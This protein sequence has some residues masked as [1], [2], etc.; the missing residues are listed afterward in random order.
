MPTPVLP[1]LLAAAAPPASG[2]P[3]DGAAHG[4]KALPP[5]L[6]ALDVGAP[7]SDKVSWTTYSHELGALAVNL[8]VAIVVLIATTWMARTLS[9]V[10]RRLLTR[11]NHGEVDG[12]LP[13]FGASVTRYLVTIIGVVAALQQ[14]GVRTTSVLAVLGA[15]SLAVGLALQGALSNVAA[16]VMIMLFRPYRIGHYVEIGGKQGVVKNLDL[17]ATEMATPDNLRV[18]VPNSKVFGDVITNWSAHDRRRVDVVFHVP[19]Q[20]DLH[21]VLEGLKTYLAGHPLAID[22]PEPILEAMTLN[23]LYAE[24]AVRVWVKPADYTA[25]RTALVLEAQ[26]LAGGQ[27]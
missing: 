16:G 23:E 12:T 13:A 2:A 18:I 24:G 21:A 4:L 22:T 15:A 7:L 9:G 11:A 6:R 19:I 5:D 1:S 10:V 3:A 27:S 20:R 8:A 14:L 17:F 26:R 25:L